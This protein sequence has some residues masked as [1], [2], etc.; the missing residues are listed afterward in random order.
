MASF[1]I[2]A[3]TFLTAEDGL[4][5]TRSIAYD[6]LVLD[7]GLPD[8]D[9]LDVIRELRAKSIRTPILILTARGGIDER[10]EGL[11]RGADDYLPKPF[12]MKELAARLRALLRRPGGP[13]GT[14]I[15]IANLS[16][17]TAARQVKVDGRVV[18]ISRR[19]LDALEILVRRADQVVPKRLLEDT[20][21]GLSNDVTS[22][23][24]EALVSAPATETGGHAC[25]AVSIHTSAGD[26]LPPQGVVS[27]TGTAR[28]R[29]LGKII[30]RLMITTLVGT[31]VAYGWLYLKATHVQNYLEQRA[32]VQQAR[33]ISN[34][35]AVSDNG[36][37][38][39][40]NPRHRACRKPITASRAATAMRSATRPDASSP[41]PAA[42]S[43]R[44]RC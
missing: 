39:A 25:V 44:S 14:T 18:A 40:L 19:E 42:G 27:G 31:G 37:D 15:D 6:A 22:N 20:I 41:P 12:A 23:T 13:L 33:D 28:C 2:G 43:V 1:G 7:L 10:V 35:I 11:D 38:I 4:A 3:D 36:G 34:F 29:L 9:G 26:R 32:L 8:R 21:Y 24:I 17:D 5:A 16:L 30:Q